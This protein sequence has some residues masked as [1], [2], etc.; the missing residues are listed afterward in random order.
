[1]KKHIYF[2][3]SEGKTKLHGVIW[4]PET[5]PKAIVQIVHGMVEYV[6]RYEIFAKFLNEHGIL[7]A[8]HDHLGH[9]SSYTEE[10]QKGY[11]A[12][13]KGDICAIQDMHRMTVL[14]QRKYPDI[15]HFIFGHSMGSFLTRRYLCMYPNEVDGAIISGTGWKPVPV[16][17]GG[18]GVVKLLSV[19][20]GDKFRSIF[21]TKLAFGS[22]NKAFEPVKTSKDWISRD[23]EVCRKYVDDPNCG[24]LFTL[25]GY[26]VLFRSMLMAQNAELMQRMDEDLP[27]LFIAGEMDPVGDFGKGVKK[28]VNAFYESGMYDVECILYPEARHELTNEVNKAEVFQDI[29]EW[30]EFR[31]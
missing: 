31:I 12:K 22:I 10:W 4:E 24:F 5:Q 30:I 18:L 23:V 28:T 14:L 17:K 29:L 9:G 26:H 25:N 21:V 15:P 7:V 27:V 2:P 19:L 6:E 20:K 16:L 8:G 11:F 1:M 3:S 13:E